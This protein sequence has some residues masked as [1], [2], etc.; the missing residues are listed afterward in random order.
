VSQHIKRMKEIA[1]N[2]HMIPANEQCIGHLQMAIQ[3]FMREVIE[4]LQRAED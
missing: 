4:E 2:L 1:E 3:E